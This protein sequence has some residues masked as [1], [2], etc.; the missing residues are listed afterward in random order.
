VVVVMVVVVM[1]VVASFCVRYYDAVI[2]M[3]VVF[4]SFASTV[5]GQD[6]FGSIFYPRGVYF[7]FA[8]ATTLGCPC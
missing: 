2:S 7:D 1:V 3:V 8:L 4:I 5:C 6:K